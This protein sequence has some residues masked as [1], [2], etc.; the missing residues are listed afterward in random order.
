MTIDRWTILGFL[1]QFI[2]SLRFLYQ[3]IISEKK[4]KSVVPKFFWYLSVLGGV[5]LLIYA[6]QRK[7][8]VFIL[9]Q[10]GGL[11]IYLR[12]IMLYRE[13]N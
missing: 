13:I 6:I 7:D 8:L 2:F 3:W 9:G 5:L 12:N 1:A 4:K 11:I 10:S